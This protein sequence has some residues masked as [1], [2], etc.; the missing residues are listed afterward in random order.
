MGHVSKSNRNTARAHAGQL[1][2]DGEPYILHSMRVMLS[3][4]SDTER[5]CAILHDV[6]E[7]TDVTIDYLH[8]QGFPDSVKLCSQNPST[9]R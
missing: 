3:L 2:T 8:Q 1:D 9:L 4:E 6:L 5:V 7:D